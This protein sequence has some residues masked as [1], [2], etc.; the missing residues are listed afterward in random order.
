MDKFALVY[1]FNNDSPLIVYKASK[2]LEDNN[3][4][5]AIEMLNKA[6]EDYPYYPTPHFLLATA[7]AYNHEFEEAQIMLS[8]AH[9]ILDN[10]QTYKYYNNLIEKIKRESD[11]INSNFDD[12]VNKVLD[13]TFLDSDELE[14]IDLL[15]IDNPTDDN[16]I[17]TKI[18]THLP[19]GTIV[20]ETLAE[21]YSSQGNYNEA[22]EIYE[23]LKYIYPDKAEKFEK[24]ILELSSTTSSKK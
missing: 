10:E 21:I 11:G 16:T 13:E 18:N 2:E 1:E 9:N 8:K 17:L 24:K 6:I 23:K 3:I 12:T 14:S 15:S 20:T 4:A 5:K 7:L 19:D 22:K